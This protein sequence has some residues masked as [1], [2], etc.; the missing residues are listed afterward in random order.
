MAPFSIASTPMCRWGHYLFPWMASC[1][2]DSYSIML[3]VKQGDKKYHSSSLWYD[4]TRYWTLV[5]H[6]ISKHSNHYADGP[7]ISSTLTTEINFQFRKQEKSCW[8]IYIVSIHNP[9][10]CQTLLIKYHWELLLSSLDYD[11]DNDLDVWT[12]SIYYIN[13]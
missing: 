11:L 4:S 8:E 9:V 10:F 2:L 5:S 12:S 1:T 13:S 7:V 3:S 6:T